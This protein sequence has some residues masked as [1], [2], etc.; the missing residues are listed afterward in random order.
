MRPANVFVAALAAAP[1]T[2]SAAATLGFALGM[3]NP[4]G[5]CKST[6]DYKDDFTALKP[7]TSLVRT[8]A[9][10]QCNQS[11]NIIPAAQSAGFQV[12][13]GVWPDTEDSFNNDVA[14]LQASV[15]GNEGV[16]YGITVGS[17]TLYRG[18]FTGPEL[19]SKIQT[20]QNLFPSVT[21]GTADSWNKYADGTAD[22][23]ITGGVKLLLANAF[24]YWQGQDISNA[25]ATYFDDMQQAIGHI[26]ELSGSLDAVH[27]MT[28]ETGWPTDGGTN[29]E[30]AMAGTSNA[31]TFW[32][33]GVCGMLD[34]GVDVF[35]FEAF[36]EPGKQAT[37]GVDGALENEQHWGALN[38]DRSTKFSLSCGS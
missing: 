1:L 35:Y 18:N 19:L 20:V 10:S 26:Q 27:V 33:S 32:Q 34:W 21:V 22:A 2:V 5:S 3:T 6:S 38:A 16:V 7:Y 31:N 25:T 14:A 36:D 29:Y 8:Y 37:V 4:D 30:A 13:L 15:P 17:E 12:L 24:S 23:L 28:G 11:Q 9:A